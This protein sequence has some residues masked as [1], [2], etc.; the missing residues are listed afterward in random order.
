MTLR[1]LQDDLE[2]A[3]HDFG[4]CV[5]RCKTREQADA[6]NNANNAWCDA[7]EAL[8]AYFAKMSAR[9][10]ASITQNDSSHD[11]I[12]VNNAV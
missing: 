2:R 12:V 8:R 7:N 4:A 1:R 10:I 11:A 6:W 5:D 3:R 9:E